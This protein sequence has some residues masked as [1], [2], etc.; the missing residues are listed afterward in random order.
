MP[1]GPLGIETVGRFC[2]SVGL[3]CGIMLT[4][5]SIPI[6]RGSEFVSGYVESDPISTR[7]ESN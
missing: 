2:S 3:S 1:T 7:R 5:D 6:R 4:T